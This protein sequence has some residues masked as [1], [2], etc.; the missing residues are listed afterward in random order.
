MNT[1]ESQ[2]TIG[3]GVCEDKSLD[4]LETYIK[5]EISEH[6]VVLKQAVMESENF[7][8]FMGEVYNSIGKNF[9][10]IEKEIKDENEEATLL[11]EYFL[12]QDKEAGSSI[13]SEAGLSYELSENQ[14]NFF[15]SVD[16]M[17]DFIAQ[18]STLSDKIV[19]GVEKV[20]GIMKSIEEIR[21]L[22]DQIKVYS[23]NAII[24]SSKHGVAG[25]AFGE[26]SKNIIKLSDTSNQQA[27]LMAEMGQS[28]FDGF[29]RFKESIISV[30]QAQQVQFDEIRSRVM[31]AYDKLNST[32]KVF[33]SLIKDLI[34]R[35]DTTKKVIFEIMMVL[36]R[37]D[38][39]RQHSEHI[40]ESITEII[41]ESNN[42]IQMLGE[43]E[44][45]LEEEY[46]SSEEGHSG[47]SVD[48]ERLDKAFLDLL[49]FSEK[50][51]TLVIM[52]L[53]TVEKE[54]ISTN[55]EVRGHLMDM[56]QKIENIQNDRDNII[57]FLAGGDAN[58]KESFPISALD[59][60]FDEYLSFMRKYV[61]QFKKSLKAKDDISEGNGE[62]IET[63]ENLEDLFTDAKNI[64]RTFNSINFL[65]KIE[66]EKNVKV[67]SQTKAFSLDSVETIASN[68][69]KTVNT[70]LG[71]FSV[72]KEDLYNSLKQFSQSINLQNEEYSVI[73]NRIKSVDERLNTSKDMIKENINSLENYARNLIALI[74]STAE[75]MQSIEDLLK[76]IRTIR[77]TFSEIH[78]KISLK[79]SEFMSLLE[80]NEW[81][82]S[83]DKYRTIV[84]RY[85][86]RKE[87]MV[88]NDILSDAFEDVG[89][90]SGDL[91]LF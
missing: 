59:N 88:A 46:A 70:C 63:I 91:T 38:I 29:E 74:D 5:N 26:I 67:F 33:A 27:D 86:I 25:R 77:A 90:E 17:Q 31:G 20:N 61:E 55:S 9:P 36:Q 66:L 65:A 43:E 48:Q 32:F 6:S 49:T 60:A 21:S 89:S 13:S 44:E 8:S 34:E 37:E 1:S 19:S 7:I 73:K 81:S 69:S 35:V 10:A 2:N 30:N 80:I 87:R 82:L 41:D 39:I 12:Y 28:L 18:D 62:I 15:D 47:L 58:S 45:K 51:L 79:R 78:G 53:D 3:S 56:R 40:V 71:G 22:A 76:D 54:I 75:D 14:K 52:Q 42:F 11:I 84:N 16:K 72:I 57:H 4:K 68:I 24:V 85:T 83:S 64:S 23:L 50:I